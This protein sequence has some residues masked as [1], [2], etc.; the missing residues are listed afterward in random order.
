MWLKKNYILFIIPL[1]IFFSK[2]A[3]SYI[4]FPSDFTITKVLFDT[5]DS[6]YYPIVKSLANFDFS[7]SYNESIKTEN[8]LTFPYGPIILHSVFYNIFGNVSFIIIEYVFIFLFFLVIFKIFEHIGF[9]FNSS[10][11]S[12]LLIL[13]LP[14]LSELLSN[15]SI[16]YI[17]NLKIVLGS[18]FS[19]RFPRPQVTGLYYLA[20]IYLSLKFSVN[21]KENTNKKYSILFALILGL[22]LNSFFYFFIYCCLA[23]LI[24]L[25]VKLKKN[26]LSF[27]IFKINFLLVFF[28]LL[29]ITSIPFFLQLYFG[30]TDHSTRIGLVEINLKDKIYLNNFFLKSLLRFEPLIIFFISIFLTIVVKKFFKKEKLFDKID[31]FFYLYLSSIL[32]PFLFIT[33][34]SKV[35]AIYHFANYILVNGLLY[36]SFSSLSIL[37][38]YQKSIADNI[39]FKKNK[40][41]KTFL[42]IVILFLFTLQNYNILKVKTD[43]NIFNEIN[44][45]FIENRIVNSKTYLFT[46]DMRVANLWTFNKNNN[47]LISDGYT[48]AIKN[49]TIVENLAIGLKLIGVS[50]E[51]FKKILDFKGPH[52]TQRNPIIQHLFNYQYQANKFKQFSDDEQ[53]TAGELERINSTSPLRVMANILPQDEKD[54]FLLAFD[55]VSLE[56]NNYKDYVVI[57]NTK[58]IPDF[59][60]NKNYENFSIIFRKDHYIFLKKN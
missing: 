50:R 53:Y 22:I 59:F 48:N 3:I 12:T 4:I 5:P 45:I 30:E 13:F 34:S 25:I 46:N 18:I 49:K 7:P 9:S 2:W 33:F 40:I 32:T 38:F 31:I 15:F 60:K 55:N 47:L 20:F 6:Q 17:E 11:F 51:E 37:Y 1:V 27:I 16:A 36:I 24:L 10:L 56:E 41:I 54:K 14:T 8:L 23:L 43:R 52:Y 39:I 29:L 42:T 21:I 35:I 26:L 19:S 44:Q 28:I 57:L 58:L